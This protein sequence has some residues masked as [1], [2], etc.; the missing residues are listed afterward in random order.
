M[1]VQISEKCNKKFYTVDH[2]TAGIF[3]ICQY[4]GGQYHPRDSNSI[5]IFMD[6]NDLNHHR[7]RGTNS[8]I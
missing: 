1:K 5:E 8:M 7:T 2:N 3:G 4:I 6:N